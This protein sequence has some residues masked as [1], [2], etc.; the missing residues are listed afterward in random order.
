MIARAI[1]IIQSHAL[2]R[3]GKR[4]AMDF[5]QSQAV[6]GLLVNGCAI[7]LV[8]RKAIIGINGVDL[9]HKGIAGGLCQDGGSR[10]TQ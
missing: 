1:Y 7:S 10:D 5:A 2:H 3:N 8:A 9:A 4:L 6:D